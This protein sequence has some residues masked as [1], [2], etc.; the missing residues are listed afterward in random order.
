MSTL[1]KTEKLFF[2]YVQKVKKI[3]PKISY[4]IILKQENI[5]RN[6]FKEKLKKEEELKKKEILMKKFRKINSLSNLKRKDVY[7]SKKNDLRNLSVLK[8]KTE[9]YDDNKYFIE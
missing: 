3:D 9:S 6:K 4:K 1:K 2:N 5:R 8:I 7:R